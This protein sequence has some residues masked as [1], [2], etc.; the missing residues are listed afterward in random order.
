M[1]GSPDIEISRH[2][3]SAVH[4]ITA[5]KLDTLGPDLRRGVTNQRLISAVLANERGAHLVSKADVAAL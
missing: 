4:V 3:V 5:N 1:R 2:A